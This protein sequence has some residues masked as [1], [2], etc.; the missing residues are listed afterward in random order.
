MP[1]KEIIKL[2]NHLVRI[3]KT[4]NP[5]KIAL[6]EGFDV[7]LKDYS[8]IKGYFYSVLKRKFIVVNQNLDELSK[9]IVCAHELG[10]GMLHNVDETCFMK[11]Y[12]L[13]PVYSRTEREAN[14][15]AAELIINDDWEYDSFCKD[16]I[17]LGDDVFQQ[18]LALKQA[19][20]SE[21]GYGYVQTRSNKY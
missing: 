16:G 18:L 5:F 9:I 15:F 12:T 10:H 17:S 21:L 4:R 11:E 2:A 19:N 1:L 20:S 3:Q 8:D 14:A 7:K 13:F 6:Y